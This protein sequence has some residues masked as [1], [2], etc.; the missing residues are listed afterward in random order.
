MLE[1]QG[2][3]LCWIV[4]KDLKKAIAFYTETMGLTLSECHENYGWAELSSSDGCALGLAQESDA[5]DVLS[6]S[7]AV[8]TLSVP[9]IEA[10]CKTCRAK[11]VKLIAKMLEI[12]G[13]VKLQ[14]VEDPDGNRWQLVEKLSSSH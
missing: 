1:S 2:I 14:T 12:P 13:H 4:V 5:Q 10:A 3:H 8:L 6:G 7:N 11:G 9:D